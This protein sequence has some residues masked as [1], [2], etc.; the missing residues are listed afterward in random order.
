MSRLAGG[1]IGA[2][3]ELYDRHSHSVWRAVSRTLPGSP[4]VEDVVHAT[5]LTLP[6]IAPSYD[7]RSGGGSPSGHQQ[8]G[9]H[10]GGESR[11]GS[12]GAQR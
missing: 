8:A 2:L 11:G 3:G 1:E 12:R 4:D 9:G 5:F 10:G 6:R 7:G